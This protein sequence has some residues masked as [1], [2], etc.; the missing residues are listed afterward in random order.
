MVKALELDPDFLMAKMNMAS[1]YLA[2]ARYKEARSV[3][4]D[5]LKSNPTNKQVRAALDY[6]NT[7]KL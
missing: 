5:V 2:T 1:V 6:L 7:E 4:N 3:L